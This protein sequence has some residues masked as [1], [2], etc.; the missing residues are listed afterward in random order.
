MPG[1]CVTGLQL[2]DQSLHGKPV[3]RAHPKR[4]RTTNEPFMREKEL[5]FVV[6][7]HRLREVGETIE[8]YDEHFWRNG[9]SVRMVV[10]DD[11][12]PTNQQKYYPLL[13]QTHTHQELHYVG[14]REKEQFLAYPSCSV[15][16][17]GMKARDRSCTRL[18]A[19]ARPGLRRPCS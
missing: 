6:P 9:H 4:I 7:T 3:P 12:T 15:D 8:Q 1:H 10:F 17:H 14:P 16:S 18:P 13:E 11:S 2:S 19:L 5:S